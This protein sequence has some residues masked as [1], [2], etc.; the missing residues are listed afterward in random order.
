MNKGLKFLS[1]AVR[2]LAVMLLTLSVVHEAF[3]VDA[4]PPLKKLQRQRNFPA[5]PI[6][7]GDGA[8]VVYSSVAKASYRGPVLIFI[9]QTRTMFLQGLNMKLGS[10][11]CP[12]EVKI[13]DK[14]DGD[15]SVLSARIRDVKGGLRERIELP[16][17]EAA[18]L[19]KFRRAIVVAFLRAYMLEAGGTQ[20]TMQDL[21]NWL[22][23]GLLRH[24]IGNK[25][26]ADLDRTHL[27]W[28]NGCIPPAEHLYRF[29]SYA[30]KQE[31]AVAA[32]LAGWFMERRGKAFK[33]LIDDVAK[34][35]KWSPEYVAKLL[36]GKY[37]GGF[38]MLLDMR[39][40]ALGHRVIQPGV[41]TKGIMRRFKSELLLFPS[42]YGMMFKQEKP[43]YTFR[44]AVADSGN[45]DLRRAARGQCVR[46][47]MASVG[48][49]GMLIAVADEYLKFLGA[50][51]AGAEQKKL[52]QMLTQAESMQRA[53]E[54]RL[55]S[56]DLR[57]QDLAR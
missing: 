27:L 40:Y 50:F 7:S 54:Q 47:K 49:D 21:P 35:R 26:Q 15:T 38:D 30:A 28:S 53:L 55:E 51:V 39:L 17:A 12:L 52:M 25:R 3:G 31:L 56:G 19:T 10:L 6:Y 16:D 18:D 48:R 43:C 37:A 41:S 29:D 11:R 44:E 42:D 36:S 4:M 33:V 5:A 46:V 57:K 20:Q 13:G 22:I 34:G 24:L 14:N 2:L 1:G 45:I 23:D 8:V 9:N 32:V